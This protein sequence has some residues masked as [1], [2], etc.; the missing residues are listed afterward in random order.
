MTA[1]MLRTENRVV[2]CANY[3]ES[4]R[5]MMVLGCN[6]IEFPF[7]ASGYPGVVATGKRGKH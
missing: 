7:A 4:T 6:F 1:L 3:N 5:K 2:D